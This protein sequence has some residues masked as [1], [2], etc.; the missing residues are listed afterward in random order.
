M[1]EVASLVIGS[2]LELQTIKM[3]GNP[4]FYMG[5]VDEVIFAS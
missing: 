2:T 1:E 3:I 4:S 5:G